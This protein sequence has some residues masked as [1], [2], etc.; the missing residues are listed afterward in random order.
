MRYLGGVTHAAQPVVTSAIDGPLGSWRQSS[1]RPARLAG[2]VEGVWL[3]DGILTNRRER[4]FPNGL[5]EI[6]VHLGDRYRLV[7]DGGASC[8]Q[9]CPSTCVTGLQL[10]HL[11]VEAPAS[12]T[13]VLGI[14]LTPAGAYAIFARPM[15]EITRLTVDA[16]DL[17]GTAADELSETCGAALAVSHEACLGAA[18]GWIE[19]RLGFGVRLDPAVEWMGG[20]IRRRE[21]AASIAALRERTGWSKSRLT[22]T[23]LHQ[24][25]VTPKQ[26]ARVVRFNHALRRLHGA[27]TPLS[28][29]AADCG[30]Y[31]QPHMTADF[32]ELSGLTPVEFVRAIRYPLSINVAEEA[33]QAT[34][35]G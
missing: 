14:R 2:F 23:F 1:C 32:R 5:L 26:L 9:L 15:H 35:R 7:E 17:L 30:Y 28:E 16:A 18:V 4:T 19:A 29:L 10:G 11:V 24:V 6:F 27:P 25:G 21:G 20:E 33:A 34:T 8:D 3:F 13:T 12:R 31:D 22:S